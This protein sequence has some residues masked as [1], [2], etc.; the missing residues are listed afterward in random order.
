MCSSDLDDR[1][2]ECVRCELD[3]EV[4]ALLRDELGLFFTAA[5]DFLE[6]LLL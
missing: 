3:R 4:Y 6:E 2:D 1:A 5:D